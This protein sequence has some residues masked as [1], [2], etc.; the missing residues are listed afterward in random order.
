LK[1]EIYTDPAF[2]LLCRKNDADIQSIVEIL[3]ALLRRSPLNSPKHALADEIIFLIM[4]HQFHESSET[5]Y[6]LDS[7]LAKSV[8]YMA[9]SHPAYVL[10]SQS[11]PSMECKLNTKPPNL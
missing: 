11:S 4:R 2:F 1:R 9:G 10:V 7:K 6:L 8:D 3:A 5:C